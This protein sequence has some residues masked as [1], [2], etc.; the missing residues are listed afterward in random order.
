MRYML[1]AAM[2]AA[3]AAQ[4]KPA[5]ARFLSDDITSIDSAGKRRDKAAAVAEMPVGNAQ[6]HAEIP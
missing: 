3:I 2:S 5:Y 6:T 1:T 4:D